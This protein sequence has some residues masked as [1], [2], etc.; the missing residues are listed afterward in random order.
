MKKTDETKTT[1]S[2]RREALRELTNDD[3]RQVAAAS[4]ECLSG[5]VAPNRV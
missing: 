2:L 4:G 5:A 3:L 1:L